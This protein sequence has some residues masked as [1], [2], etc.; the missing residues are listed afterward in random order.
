MKRL[1][2]I[3]FFELTIIPEI[4]FL[5]LFFKFDWIL[6]SLIVVKSTTIVINFPS[7]VPTPDLSVK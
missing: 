5:I 4:Y 3:S 1:R 2:A 7:H 6:M